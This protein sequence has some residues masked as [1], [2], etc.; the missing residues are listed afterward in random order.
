MNNN[1][2]QNKTDVRESP[3]EAKP[4]WEVS[5]LGF[6]EDVLISVVVMVVGVGVV[7]GSETNMRH[8]TS[9]LMTTVLLFNA[10]LIFVLW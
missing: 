9:R 1:E 8:Y 5:S 7:V 2:Q 6:I 4:A 3:Q 10:F